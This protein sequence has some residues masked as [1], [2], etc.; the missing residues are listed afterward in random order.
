MADEARAREG[1]SAAEKV[2]VLL[3]LYALG[4]F[5]VFVYVGVGD[6]ISAG[7]VA[8]LVAALA[9]CG[10]FAWLGLRHPIAAGALLVIPCAFPFGL[11]MAGLTGASSAGGVVLVL[12]WFAGVPLAAGLIL[13]SE[14]VRDRRERR[15]LHDADL[16][17]RPEL[18]A[19]RS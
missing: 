1:K 4:W 2:A 16:R 5:A 8:A 9:W 18:P 19:R 6:G 12:A 7:D 10:G 14:G 13:L 17:D 15:A 3:G 11:V